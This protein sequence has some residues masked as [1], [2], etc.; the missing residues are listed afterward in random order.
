M[1][2]DMAGE[3]AWAEDRER[4]TKGAVAWEALWRPGRLATAFARSAG[5][6]SRTNVVYL[7]SSVDARIAGSP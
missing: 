6:R 3:E 5:R 7:A 2:E 1:Q 4:V